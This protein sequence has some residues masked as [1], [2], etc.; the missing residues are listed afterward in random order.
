NP[1]V[2]P[3]SVTSTNPFP[4]GP[5]RPRAARGAI[6]NEVGP[7]NHR[8]WVLGCVCF[9]LVGCL[10][11][12]TRLQSAE[13]PEQKDYEVKTIGEVTSVGNYAP[14]QVSGVGLVTGLDGTGGGAPPGYFKNML[15]EQLRKQGVENTKQVLADPR[16]ALVLVSAM[17]PPGARK[18]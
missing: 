7:M 4:R 11:P 6:T 15:E 3:L 17:V 12:Q 16:N 13:E 18:G 1:I 9:A 14:L 10:H 5:I 2:P 8:L